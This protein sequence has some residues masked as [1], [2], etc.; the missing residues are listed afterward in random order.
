MTLNGVNDGEAK[1]DAEPATIED[2]FLSLRHGNQQD[3]DSPMGEGSM[4]EGGSAGE[5]SEDV[6]AEGEAQGE[7]GNGAIEEPTGSNGNDVPAGGPAAPSATTEEA[8]EVDLGQIDYTE[9]GK[10]YIKSTQ[11]LAIDAANKLFR[12]NNVTKASINDLYNKDENGRVSFE[13]PDDP[14]RPFQSR[15]E[16]QQWVDAF[17][18]QVDS[19]WRRVVQDQQR[20][21]M[22]DI[23]PMLRLIDFAPEFEQMSKQEQEVFDSIVDGYAIKDNSG[24]TIGYS[25]DLRN[26]KNVAMNICKNMGISDTGNDAGNSAQK[27]QL[28]GGGPAVD[29]PTSGTGNPQ[30]DVNEPKDLAEAMKM[31]AEQ[32]KKEKNNG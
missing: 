9:V 11:R 17:N 27:Q 1:I 7:N 2:A 4:G 18:A 6:Q 23:Q 19:E 29:A 12:D 13:N 32:K 31:L 30:N 24:M 26:A 14:D 5:G 16:A 22:K 8:D 3:P 10:E 20:A 28:Q 15:A 25:C 21:Y